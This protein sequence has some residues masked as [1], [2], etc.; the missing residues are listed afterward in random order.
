[1]LVF[2]EVGD[3]DQCFVDVIE[4]SDIGESR[5]EIEN[6]SSWEEFDTVSEERLTDKGE[7]K[8]D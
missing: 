7:D 1:M 4:V 2:E 5:C 6:V 8:D 3:T